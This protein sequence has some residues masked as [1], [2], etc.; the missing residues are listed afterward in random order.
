[1]PLLHTLGCWSMALGCK[2]LESQLP[3]D[4]PLRHKF[5]RRRLDLLDLTDLLDD[6][7]AVFQDEVGVNFQIFDL[8]KRL[9]ESWVDSIHR[10]PER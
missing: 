6:P 2:V 9:V 8:E 4:Q 5:L 10:S 1:M 3:W 7:K